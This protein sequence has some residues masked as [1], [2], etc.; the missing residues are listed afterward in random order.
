MTTL[1]HALFFIVFT[2]TIVSLSSCWRD[3]LGF[4]CGEHITLGKLKFADSTKTFYSSWTGKETL[5]F[6]DSLGNEE[7]FASSKGKTIIFNNPLVIKTLCDSGRLDKQTER[8][9][10]EFHSVDFSGPNN[11][12]FQLSLFSDTIQ[13]KEGL[14]IYDL[15]S[16][17]FNG[18]SLGIALQ[19]DNQKIIPS[20]WK[21]SSIVEPK[22]VADTVIMGK[23]FK[24]VY[25]ATND[26]LKSTVYF[27]KTK[28][29][30]GFKDAGKTWLFDRI[31]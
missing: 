27:Q 13:Q 17:Y 20:S 23:N 24:N 25:Y 29:I 16:I 8:Y 31:K 18:A 7:S 2:F 4:Q 1:K 26:F 9:D 21:G 10:S 12:Y 14:I 30:I 3:I 15:F 11:H 28:M 6:K 5:V 19:H 22:F